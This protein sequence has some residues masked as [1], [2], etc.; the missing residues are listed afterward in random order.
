MGVSTR[1]AAIST[2]YNIFAILNSL[3]AL[4]QNHNC[5]QEGFG[6]KFIEFM[7]M[8]HLIRSSRGITQYV[9]SKVKKIYII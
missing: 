7:L 8:R 5:F 6:K 4:E 9:Y 3:F 1:F 2:F